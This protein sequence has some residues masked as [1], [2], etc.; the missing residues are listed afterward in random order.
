M[1][2]MRSLFMALLC[3]V[4]LAGCGHE[5]SLQRE[6]AT[7][8]LVSFPIQSDADVFSSAGRHDAL[9][10]MQDK[11]P[12]GTRIV[13]EGELPKVSEAADRAWGPQIGPNRIWGIQFTCR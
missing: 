5:A 1:S 8:G 3:A 7:G 12:S 13:K 11:C 4:E 9:R 10:I 6:T 2:G